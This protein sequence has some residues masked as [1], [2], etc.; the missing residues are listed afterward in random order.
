MTLQVDSNSDGNLTAGTITA[1]GSGYSVGDLVGIVTS[2]LGAGQ[3]SGSGALFSIDSIS[4]TDTL[5]LTDV[6]GQTFS[7]NA[8]LLH[9]NGTNYVALTNNKLVEEIYL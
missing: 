5:Y 6:Q 9:F 3:Q 7:N 2:S 4:A 1:G 8:A